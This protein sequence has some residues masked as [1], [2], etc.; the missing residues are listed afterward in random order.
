MYGTYIQRKDDNYPRGSQLRSPTP[1][2]AD[3]MNK[4]LPLGQHGGAHGFYGGLGGGA[5]CFLP[6]TGQYLPTTPAQ[7]GL[8]LSRSIA[9]QT[10]M[11]RTPVWQLPGV[12]RVSTPLPVEIGGF[13]Q[14]VRPE[15]DRSDNVEERRGEHGVHGGRYIEEYRMVRRMSPA[16][17]REHSSPLRVERRAGNRSRDRSFSRTIESVFGDKGIVDHWGNW[18]RNGSKEDKG[19]KRTVRRTREPR[20]SDKKPRSGRRATSWR[21]KRSSSEES[22]R[23]RRN[24]RS[25]EDGG[26]KNR[27]TEEKV[28]REQKKLIDKKIY[29]QDRLEQ[30]KRREEKIIREE[31]KYKKQAQERVDSLKRE[32]KRVKKMEEDRLKKERD[33]YKREKKLLDLKRD[34]RERRGSPERRSFH[35]HRR[36]KS[37]SL[38]RD[39]SKKVSPRPHRSGQSS[40]T[41]TVSL[42]C[43]PVRRKSLK[44]DNR[45]FSDDVVF[46]SN[47]PSPRRRSFRPRPRSPSESANQHQSVLN[48]LGP[49]IPVRARL[50]L[51]KRLETLSPFLSM[52]SR[53][54]DED[55]DNINNNSGDREVFTTVDQVGYTDGV[56]EV[57]VKQVENV[58][59]DLDKVVIKRRVK[60]EEKPAQVQISLD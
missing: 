56:K 15:V 20:K 54:E 33:L 9:F 2:H 19:E 55:E 7:T 11:G 8:S 23:K 25:E 42:S 39:A 34:E 38:K 51:R 27:V 21:R 60:K 53:G 31:D 24:Y 13:G 43:S 26:R 46:A 17:V 49:K 41:V 37:S 57:E 36:Q 6:G 16:E 1:L 22:G 59:V 5:N 30:V 47:P 14:V 29:E 32:E 44:T 45:K 58:T 35:L 52:S 4:F 28:H 48:R 18:Q 40:P 3:H 50:G 12:G 10:G